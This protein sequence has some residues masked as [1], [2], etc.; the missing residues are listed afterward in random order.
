MPDLD[1]LCHT[2]IAPLAPPEV[3]FH[4]M[5]MM[6]GGQVDPYDFHYF[7]WNQQ[8]LTQYLSEAGFSRVERVAEFGLF[9]DTSSYKPYGAPISLNMIATK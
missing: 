3:K 6:F 5:R 9:D 4:V 8:F 2:F 7:G 1:I